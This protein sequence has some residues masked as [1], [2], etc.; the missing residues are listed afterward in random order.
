MHAIVIDEGRLHWQERPD[1]QAGDH[2]LLVAVRAAGVN[3]ADLAQRDG[4]LSGAA[5]VAAGHP[6][7]GV[8]RRG[9]ERGAARDA[10]RA[11]RPRHGARRRRS[12]GDAGDGRRSARAGGAGWACLA[13]GRR[14]HG[15]VR[16]RLRRALR[17][18][19][20]DARR[21]GP[22]QRRRRRR[23][24]RRGPARGAGRRP[25]GRLGARPRPA[26]HRQGT[27]RRRGASSPT[28]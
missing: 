4:L 27:R 24:Q 11:G 23:G 18:G 25:C 21:E 17:P 6:R 22:D 26:R 9:R 20:P 7:P 10:V 16:Y 19:S 8:R 12:P 14:L 1:P 15:G 13:G 5:R 28:T 3:S 2:E